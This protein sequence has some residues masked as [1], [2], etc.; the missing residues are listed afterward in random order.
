[1]FS[2]TTE[3]AAQIR[4]RSMTLKGEATSSYGEKQPKQSASDKGA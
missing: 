3:F 4:K 2:L 1:M